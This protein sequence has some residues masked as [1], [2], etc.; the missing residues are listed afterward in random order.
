[1]L[2]A[3]EETS[4]PTGTM[5][6]FSSVPNGKK[7]AGTDGSVRQSIGPVKPPTSSRNNGIDGVVFIVEETQA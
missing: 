7:L 2:T 4:S 1:M 6:S 5:L 3:G